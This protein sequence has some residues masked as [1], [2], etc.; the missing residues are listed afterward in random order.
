LAKKLEIRPADLTVTVRSRSD[1]NLKSISSGEG[2][3]TI[4][5]R[6]RHDL[7]SSAMPRWKDVLTDEQIDS[8][9]A[10]LRFLGASQHELLGDP[11]VGRDLDSRS[12]RVCHGEDGEGDGIT[13]EIMDMEPMDHASSNVTERCSNEQ[14]AKSIVNSVGDFMPAWRGVLSRADVEAVVSYIRLLSS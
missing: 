7:L 6:D 4:T 10:S 8:L 13:T 14:L 5:G 11:T 12:C 3:Q 2:G 1:T 9:I